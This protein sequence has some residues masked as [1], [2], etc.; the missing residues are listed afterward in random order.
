VPQSLSNILVHI[1]F[2]TKLAR[3]FIDE[4]TRKELHPYLATVARTS[5]CDCLDVNGVADHVHLAVR[6][7]R[8]VT[9]AKLIEELKTAS[10]KWLKSRPGGIHDFAWQRGYGAFSRNPEDLQSLLGYIRG[11]EVH[12]R[13]V[14]F[15]EEYRA[16]LLE[17]GI[18][19]DERYMWD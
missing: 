10:T 2:G 1:V 8:T 16:L 19:F 17:N 6:L 12:H 9:V 15:Q 5:G 7:G 13:T 11:Q 4:A 18:E 3:P 14:S